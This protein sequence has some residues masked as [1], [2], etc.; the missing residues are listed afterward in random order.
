MTGAVHREWLASP[1]Y[2]LSHLSNAHL[3]DFTHKHTV[4]NQIQ[5]NNTEPD[6]EVKDPHPV[7]LTLFMTHTHFYTCMNTPT[8]SSGVQLLQNVCIVVSLLQG[9]LVTLPMILQGF[10]LLQRIWFVGLWVF[11]LS[12]DFFNLHMAGFQM[13][14]LVLPVVY[15]EGANIAPLVLSFQIIALLKSLFGFPV[16]DKTL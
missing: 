14:I 10:K 9:N 12:A 5:E 2:H 4:G 6:C 15:S 1:P 13:K 8:C 7:G 16:I 11:S 3:K